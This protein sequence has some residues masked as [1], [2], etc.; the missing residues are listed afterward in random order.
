MAKYVR[1]SN[2]DALRKAFEDSKSGGGN[3]KFWKPIKH[4]KYVIRFLPPANPDGLFYKETAQH[5]IGDN[6]LFCPKAEGDPC[7]ICELNKKLWDIGTD[8]S[9]ALA[10]EVKSRKQYLYNIIVKEELGKESDDPE[11]VY[12]Y[13]SGKILYDTVMDYFFDQDYGDLTDVEEGYDFVIVKE[14]GDAGFPT[15]KKSK[16]R[17]NPSPLAASDEE[18]EAILKNVH[19]LDKEVDY[20]DYNELKQ[21]LDHYLI[22]EKVDAAQYA[23]NAL[24]ESS[25][26]VSTSSA[27]Q[28]TS[29]PKKQEVEEEEDEDDLEDFEKELLAGVSEED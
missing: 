27:P 23:S 16:P 25:G 13:M 11:H 26:S 3:F 18:I 12:V 4:G 22:N 21:I 29:A 8:D 20:K 10:R 14:M 28:N 19:D 15:Y 17:R 6:Y 7:P 2:L 9:I 5:K 1:K 24:G